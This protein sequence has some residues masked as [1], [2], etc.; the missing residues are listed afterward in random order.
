[1]PRLTSVNNTPVD[2]V[3]S[4]SEAVQIV[5]SSRGVVFDIQTRHFDTLGNPYRQHAYTTVSIADARRLWTILGDVIRT[6]EDQIVDQH[7]LKLVR[8]RAA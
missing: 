5:L 2:P 3:D 8:R 6:A 7:R 1:M 4:N